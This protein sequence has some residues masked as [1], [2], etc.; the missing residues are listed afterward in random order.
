MKKLKNK[1]LLHPI[2]TFLILILITIILSGIFGMLGLST[3]YNT[4]N[5]IRGG[6]DSTPVAVKSLLNLSG[7]KLIFRTT[8]SNFSAFAPLSMLLITLIGIGIMDKSGFLSSFF[9]LV[10]KKSS[11]KTVTFVLSLIT[12]LA[13]I[14]GDISFIVFIPITALFFKYS[15]RNPKAGIILAFAGLTCGTGI[16][17]FMNSIDSALLE[18]TRLAAA[19]LDIN[20]SI[21]YHAYIIVMLFMTILMSFIITNIAEKITIPKLGKYENEIEEEQ[22][23]DK[24]KKRGLLFSLIIGSIYLLIFIYNIIPGL[25]LSG[26]LL[27]YSQELYIDKLFGY[28]SFFNQGFVFVITLFFFLCG[29]FYGL[30]AKTI[31]NNRELCNYLGHSLDGIG[32]PLVLIFF[33]STFIS[34]FKDTNIGNVLAALVADLISSISFTGIP[35]IIATFILVIITTIFVPSAVSAWSILSGV[36]VPVFMNA[37]LSAEF[38]ELIF[39][40]ASCV[41]YGLTPLMA[42]FVI[43]LAFLDSY[44]EEDKPINLFGAIKEILPYSLVTAGVWLIIFIIAYILGLPLGIGTF[45]VI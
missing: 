6:Y 10:T 20:Y 43:Y 34:I 38:A 29:L 2:M 40:G 3:S 22:Y 25:P 30:G 24:Y 39:R 15:K 1:I 33:A 21:S 17:I 41:T 31:K 23:L 27:D 42:Y 16:N 11:K 14:M 9:T 45:A 32:K 28:N 13:S 18:Y 7:L 26:N 12:I 4:V 8:V 5:A 35:L 37:G 44:S 19:S 36:V